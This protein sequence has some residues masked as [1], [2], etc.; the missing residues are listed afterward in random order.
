MCFIEFS[1]SIIVRS[2]IEMKSFSIINI[3]LSLPII[4][5]YIMELR[6]CCCIY[7]FN[8]TKSKRPTQ[9]QLKD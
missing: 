1:R 2:I 5:F 7:S 6:K 4:G 8:I 9:L 3:D